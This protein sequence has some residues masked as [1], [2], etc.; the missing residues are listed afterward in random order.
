M[1]KGSAEV[2]KGRMEEAAGVLGN[3]DKLRAKGR[4]HQA[5]GRVQQ[6]ADRGVRRAQESAGKIVD[7]AKSTAKRTVDKCKGGK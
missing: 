5:L 3:N 6:A 4:A 2:A 1:M 7:K